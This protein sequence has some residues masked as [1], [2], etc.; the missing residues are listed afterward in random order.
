MLG[1]RGLGLPEQGAPEDPL[2]L[3]EEKAPEVVA[4][5]QGAALR[6]E[7]RRG[8]AAP[9][10]RSASAIARGDHV[11]AGH[12]ADDPQPLGLGRG[13]RSGRSGRAPGR[14]S[15]AARRERP[16][17]WAGSRAAAR[18]SRSWRAREAIRRSHSSASAKPP[19][20]A[21]PLTAATTGRCALA[22]RLERRGAGLDQAL[23]VG[24]VAA[25]LARVHPRAERAAG[26]GQDHAADAVVARQRR[27]TP[28]RARPAARSR[29][30]CASRAGAGSRRRSGRDARSTADPPR[31]GS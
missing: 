10:I 17:S 22:D 4:L 1:V 9:A 23:A 13:P 12:L 11:V 29:A 18:D 31:R 21:G 26:A 27:R 5:E 30:R 2:L 3:V 7:D 6:L 14:R 8:A 28:R 16:R 24:A 19:A 20:S 15:P 25:E